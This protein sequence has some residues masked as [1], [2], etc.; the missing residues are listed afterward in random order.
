MEQDHPDHFG[1]ELSLSGLND[2]A[3]AVRALQLEKVP[4][5]TAAAFLTA[6]LLLA[7]VAKSH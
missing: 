7:A 6:A 1:Y 3:A 5:A 4:H 2:L